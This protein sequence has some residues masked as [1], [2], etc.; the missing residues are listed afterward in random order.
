M[1]CLK[2]YRCSS[3]WA[4]GWQW[5]CEK[6]N[7]YTGRIRLG[8]A[9]RF[10]RPALS[11]CTPSVQ[12][13]LYI[14]EW[15][16]RWGPCTWLHLYRCWE[17]D[18]GWLWQGSL[19]GSAVSQHC[20]CERQRRL[21]QECCRP[22]GTSHPSLFQLQLFQLFQ[23]RD[24]SVGRSLCRSVTQV[25]RAKT[26]APIETPFELSLCEARAEQTGLRCPWAAAQRTVMLS[27]IRGQWEKR[28][29]ATSYCVCH[30]ITDC[31]SCLQA[32]AQHCMQFALIY[33]TYREYDLNT[34]TE[35]TFVE[36]YCQWQL[37]RSSV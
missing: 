37:Y 20:D 33:W 1:L 22:G 31:N 21:P 18:V 15:Q 26:A 19:Q 2:Q 12:S 8:T 7:I 5:A 36:L 35:Q 25:S 27:P 11:T 23:L 17:T 28:A 30:G 16:S 34:R 10:H 9:G 24:L 29:Y 3:E 13:G 32:A 14:Y 6:E 4:A